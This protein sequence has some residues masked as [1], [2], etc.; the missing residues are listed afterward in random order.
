MGGVA[1]HCAL[2]NGVIDTVAG[3]KVRPGGGPAV[4]VVQRDR[5]ANLSRTTVGM[6]G[7][8][9]CN[10]G[11][12]A[13][14]SGIRD[15]VAVGILPELGHLQA[16]GGDVIR[17]LFI[18]HIVVEGLVGIVL[19]GR[20]L[21]GMHIRSNNTGTVR[22]GIGICASGDTEVIVCVTTRHQVPGRC[23]GLKDAVQRIAV[24]GQNIVALAVGLDRIVDR[25]PLLLVCIPLFQ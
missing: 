10:G 4:V 3:F 6:L 25:Y 8:R 16:A 18:C 2:L 14:L 21:I 22:R 13:Q 23:F 9:D 7:K 1:I 19:A 17:V 5:V 24:N 11:Q 20:D 12:L 15:G